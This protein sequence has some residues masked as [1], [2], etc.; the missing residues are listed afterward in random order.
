[1]KCGGSRKSTNRSYSTVQDE[2]DPP[3]EYG[4][5]DAEKWPVI[6]YEHLSDLNSK[7][8]YSQNTGNWNWNVRGCAVETY[9]Q[10]M[11]CRCEGSR[12]ER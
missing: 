12:Q 7:L 5:T 1:M 3:D 11:A 2:E 6:R 10:W 9:A 4:W 8:I